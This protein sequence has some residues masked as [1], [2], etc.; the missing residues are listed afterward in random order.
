ML[1]S[2]SL[3]IVAGSPDAVLIIDG[4]GCL[5][6]ANPRA[7]QLLTVP[8]RVRA[9]L[10]PSLPGVSAPL[11]IFALSGGAGFVILETDDPRQVN[12]F[13]RPSMHL[14]SWDVRA[15]IPFDYEE[16]LAEF[17]Q[18]LAQGS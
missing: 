13:L 16:D 3:A 2:L 5:Q 7:R 1:P 12:E 18:M 9:G 14:M 15:L 17:R 10:P 6:D 4:H 8:V 11:L